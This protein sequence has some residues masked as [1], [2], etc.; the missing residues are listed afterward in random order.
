MKIH[1]VPS[2]VLSALIS[3]ACGW[4]GSGVQPGVDSQMTPL[5]PHYNISHIYTSSVVHPR[6]ETDLTTT[7]CNYAKV[8]APV[9]TRLK[10]PPYRKLFIHLNSD[11]LLFLLQKW[12]RAL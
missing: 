10:R 2:D 6:A 8:H 3:G 1:T 12:L 4:M 7:M 11:S 9:Y 5:N